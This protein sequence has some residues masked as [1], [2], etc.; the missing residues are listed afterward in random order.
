MFKLMVDGVIGRIGKHA[1]LAVVVGTK[2]GPGHVI[3]QSHNLGATTARLMAH[4]IQKV[5]NAMKTYAQVCIAL[6]HKPTCKKDK[7]SGSI[8]H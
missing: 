8:F 4:R 3:T 5:R 1:H 6:V 7:I 2:K